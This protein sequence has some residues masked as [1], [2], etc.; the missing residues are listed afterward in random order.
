MFELAG[1]S[2]TLFTSWIPNGWKL[3]RPDQR[4]G[5]PGMVLGHF[6]IASL[7]PDQRSGLG[8]K[9]TGQ[10]GQQRARDCLG[11]ASCPCQSSFTFDLNNSSSLASSDERSLAGGSPM[12]TNSRSPRLSMISS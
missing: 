9:Q 2:E 5:L 3:R 7:D 12:T 4:S 1:N 8:G 10:P 11:L 6:H